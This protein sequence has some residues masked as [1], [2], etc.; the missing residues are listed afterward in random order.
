MIQRK[1]TNSAKLQV[2]LSGTGTRAGRRRGIRGG[3]EEAVLALALGGTGCRGFGVAGAK[4]A[5]LGRLGRLEVTR[6]ASCEREKEGFI[7]T[8]KRE[9][10]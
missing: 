2:D 4:L 5:E 6:F 1:E 3:A 10:P 7:F 8:E 9:Q